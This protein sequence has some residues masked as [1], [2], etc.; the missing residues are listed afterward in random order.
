MYEVI[1]VTTLC[2]CYVLF[3]GNREVVFMTV[4]EGGGCMANVGITAS[5]GVWKTLVKWTCEFL[6]YI[7]LI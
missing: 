6:N 3:N 7:S 4:R 2:C 1:G 5:Y